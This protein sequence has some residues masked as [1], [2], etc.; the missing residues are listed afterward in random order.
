MAQTF[1]NQWYDYCHAF[2]WLSFVP[3]IQKRQIFN[4]KNAEI[5]VHEGPGHEIIWGS[6]FHVPAAEETV[7]EPLWSRQFGIR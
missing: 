5:V 6:P 3:R 4:Q 2:R 7:F 1:S